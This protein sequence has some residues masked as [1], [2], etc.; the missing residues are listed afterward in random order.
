MTAI[1]RPYNFPVRPGHRETV[2]SYTRRVLDANFETVQHQRLLIAQVGG[3]THRVGRDSTWLRLL[4]VKTQRDTMHLSP[5]ATGWLTHPDGTGCKG[6][7][8]GLPERWM[9]ALCAKGARIQQN[10]HFDDLVCL[11]HHRFVGLELLPEEQISI[12]AGPDRQTLVD[13]AL[14]FRKLRRAR[15]LDVRLFRLLDTTLAATMRPITGVPAAMRAFPTVVSTVWAITRPHFQRR[16]FSPD[17]S[18]ADAFAVLTSEL[19][20]VF[21]EPQPVL[22]RA[23]WLYARA[24]FWSIRHSIVAQTSF[25]PAWAHDFPVTLA[26]TTDFAGGPGDLEPFINFLTV[27]GDDPATLAQF[28]VGFPTGRL[29]PPTTATR[30]GVPKALSICAAGHQFEVSAAKRPENAGSAPVCP[31]CEDRLIQ[32]GYNDLASTHPKVAAELDVTLNDGL[33]ANEVAAS[34]RRNLYWRC[35]KSHSYMASPFRRTSAKFGC[36]IC[37]NRIIVAGINDVATTHPDVVKLWDLRWLATASP[38]KLSADSHRMIDFICQPEGHE[39]ELRLVE[40][41]NGRGCPICERNKNR[42]GASHLATTLPGLAAEWHPTYNHGLQPSCFTHDSKDKV[43]WLCPV[44]HTYLMCIERRAAGYN[45]SVCSRP[46]LVPGVNDLATTQPILVTEFH[47][48]LNGMKSPDRIF[49]GTALYW[50]LCTAGKHKQQQSVPDR[51]ESKGCP[52]CQLE[53]RILTK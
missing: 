7:T 36:P 34:S 42:T 16:F 43:Y 45:C 49:A 12:G 17:N 32:P 51:I 10:P 28:E 20:T 35:A 31:V 44:G 27:T 23:V 8:A 33:T 2:E 5:H 3:P 46:T 13:A 11:H 1:I 53:E 22:A 41:T 19:E 24:A 6:C 14:R 40:A 18:F 29:A 47:T 39:Y 50:W 15:L 30:N 52:A 4:A 26:I 21:G 38:T 48:Y 9:C 37:S 25:E